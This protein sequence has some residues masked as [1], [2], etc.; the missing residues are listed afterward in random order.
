MAAKKIRLGII[1]AN[2]HRGW[3]ARAHLPAIP[4]SPDFELTAVCT[5]KKESAEESRQKFGARLAFADYREMLA[6]PDIDAVSVVLRVPAHYVHTM[7]ALDAGKHVYT[8]WP[9]GRD[10]AQALEMTAKAKAKGLQ[11]VVGLQ[12]RVEPSILYMKQL[13]AQGYVG[14]VLSCTMTLVRD[15][16]LS[17]PSDREWMWDA[18]LG[19][20]TLTIATGHSLDALRFVLGEFAQVQAMV[21]TQAKQWLITDT[22]K[23]VD[24]TAP[25]TVTISG[26]LVN[27]AMV[28]AH[29]SQIPFAGSNYRMEVYGT[30]GTLV[31][32]GADS[33]QMAKLTL[34]GAQGGNAFQPLEPPAQFIPVPGIPAGVPFNVGQLYRTFAEAIRT[35]KSS[36]PDF[37]TAISLHRLIDAISESSR[38]GTMQRV[39]G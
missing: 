20:H 6:H 1:G 37:D 28:S 38:T 17:R 7:A 19:A 16:A 22:K 25:D 30:K 12:A 27:G 8:E 34:A 35:G 33:P 31:V 24:V 13:V 2:I 3:A 26:R 29:V 23:T 9:L 14:E 5:T 32:T 21:G 10:T 11:R 39:G 15:G 36:A 4:A 18:T